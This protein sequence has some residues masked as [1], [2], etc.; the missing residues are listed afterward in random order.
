MAKT[1]KKFLEYKN[2]GGK[3]EFRIWR[4]SHFWSG[5]SLP[6]VKKVFTELSLNDFLDI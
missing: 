6:L 2:D 3:E 1:I 4:N 5:V